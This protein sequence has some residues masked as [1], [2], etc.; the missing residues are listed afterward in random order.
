MIAKQH[1][2]NTKKD[3]IK[4][5]T[6]ALADK[7]GFNYQEAVDLLN[8][9]YKFDFNS[10][11]NQST[12]INTMAMTTEQFEEIY[13]ANQDNNLEEQHSNSIVD[14]SINSDDTSITRNE[15]LEERE[16]I[17]QIL[18]KTYALYF[19]HGS[20]SSRKVDYFHYEI[21]CILERYFTTNDG[22]DIKLEENIPSCNSSKKK[23]CDI[24]VLKNKKP[25]IIFPV[26]IIMSNYKQNKNNS[27]ENL[28]GELTHLKWVNPNIYIIPIN[29]LMDKTTYLKN[30]KEIKN[31]ETVTTSDIENYSQLIKHNL[32]Y[33]IINY[34]VEVEH[35]NKKGECFDSIEP[36]KGFITPYRNFSSIISKLL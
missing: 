23:K 24:V 5:T 35:I 11:L 19:E 25:Y 22:Y 12:N 27:W 30:D 36:I 17:I 28:T 15:L 33:D 8:N 6:R 3:I 18:D 1:F 21:K 9:K 20:R 26:K 7:F 13:G 4:I 32:C 10:D 14:T 31:F 34:I 29:I 2:N 16:E